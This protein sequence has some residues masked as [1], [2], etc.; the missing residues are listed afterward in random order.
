MVENFIIVLEQVVILAVLIGTGA[1]AGKCG[2]LKKEAIPSLN[3]FMLNIVSVCIIIKSFYREFDPALLRSL[4]IAV[5]LGFLS[6]FVGIL[7]A[8][9][10]IKSN[11]DKE[12]QTQHLSV[13]RF[14]VVFSNCG[15][16]ALPLQNALLGEDGVFFGASY[17]A[18]MNILSWTYGLAIMKGDIKSLS[19]RKLFVNPGVIGV[20]LGLFL[21]LT[22]IVIPKV[23]IE[24]ISYLAALNTPVPMVMIGFMLWEIFH[25]G[26]F[27]I[28]KLLGSVNLYLTMLLRL[29]LVPFTMLFILTLLKVDSTVSMSIMICA[30]APTAAATTMFSEKFGKNTDV[31]V[32]LVSISTIASLITMP[33][34]IGFARFLLLGS[35]V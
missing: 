16:M 3:H 11:H 28:R 20:V 30:S 7:A 14:A 35:G 26:L 12:V 25:D 33:L 5:C 4:L 24:P 2:I 13:Y 18:I 9:C 27:R 1:V 8:H 17:V 34:I 22:G 6:H 32:T 19:A 10:I 15:F 31:S 29:V 23:V 21:F